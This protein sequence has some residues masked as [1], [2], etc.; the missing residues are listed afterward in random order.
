MLIRIDQAQ[1]STMECGDVREINPP[2]IAAT[3]MAYPT[4]MAMSTY[5]YEAEVV[6]LPYTPLYQID[7]TLVEHRRIH[8]WKMGSRIIVVNYYSSSGSQ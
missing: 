3:T 6:D 4:Q 1:S 7:S 5:A 8:L 2:A